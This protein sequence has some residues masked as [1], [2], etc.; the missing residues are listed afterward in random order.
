MLTKR[1]RTDFEECGLSKGSHP[2]SERLLLLTVDVE[3]F[4]SEMIP[5]WVE[6]IHHWATC[7]ARSG[8]R[9]CFFLAVEDMVKLREDDQGAYGDFL[10]AMRKLDDAGSLFYPHNHYAFDTK[11]GER[12]IPA[13][14]PENVP[15]QYRKRQSMFWDVV[16]RHRLDLGSWLTAVRDTYDA[17]LLE[18]GCKR[19]N[20]PVFRAGGWDYGDSCQDLQQYIAALREAGFRA[21]SS[22]CRGIFG[23]P[24]W[25]IGSH[26]GVNV[27]KLEEHLLEIAPTW[28]IDMSVR[29][30]SPPYLKTLLSLREHGKLFRGRPGAFVAVLH[31]DHL[32]RRWSRGC[33]QSFAVKDV[34]TVRKR[35]DNLFRLLAFMR[36]ILCVRCATFE[37][38]EVRK[39]EALTSL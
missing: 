14:E 13:Q 33:M 29:P 4:N 24:T 27:F 3:A 32:F 22:A 30:F 18:A 19:P 12:L 23:I 16:Y 25:R 11:S 6:A 5:P 20:V 37:D 28:S 10:K 1:L 8:L 35:I 2:V 34:E 26:F 15:R 36:S 39:Y 17:A 9:F 7:A 31:L 21:D 38:I